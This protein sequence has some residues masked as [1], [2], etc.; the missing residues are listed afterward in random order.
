M[1]AVA[2]TFMRIETELSKNVNSF[3]FF[4]YFIRGQE[5]VWLFMK[6]RPGQKAGQWPL[7]VANK[8]PNPERTP[9]ADKCTGVPQTG[10]Q[11]NRQTYRK[12]VSRTTHDPLA[13]CVKRH[14]EC[15]NN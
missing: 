11:T 5:H 3:C 7:A 4:F 14:N 1:V 15:F 10:R 13:C 2:E 6:T 8:W 12:A 9:P